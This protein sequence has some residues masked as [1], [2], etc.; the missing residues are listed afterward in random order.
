MHRLHETLSSVLIDRWCLVPPL[1][2]CSHAFSLVR[3]MTG[4]Y[5]LVDFATI[6]C[7]RHDSWAERHVSTS[8]SSTLSLRFLCFI[9]LFSVYHEEWRLYVSII[10][11]GFPRIA[12]IILTYISTHSVCVQ[13]TISNGFQANFYFGFS[14]VKKYFYKAIIKLK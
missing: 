14:L 4:V 11:L 6:Q 8:N 1:A 5:G 12:L 7:W 3:F 10:S 13:H 2:F 9:D